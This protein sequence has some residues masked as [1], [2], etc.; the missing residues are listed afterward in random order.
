MAAPRKQCES[1]PR[2]DVGSKLKKKK[3]DFMR[4]KPIH[5]VEIIRVI[6]PDQ[7]LKKVVLKIYP[8]TSSFRPTEKS[9]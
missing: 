6:H 1:S 3:G 7:N 2:G 8:P 4:I 5:V 9:L